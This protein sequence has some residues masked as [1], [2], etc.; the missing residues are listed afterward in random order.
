MVILVV[1]I[2]FF[3][4]IPLLVKLMERNFFV[5]FERLLQP[6]LHER[7]FDKRRGRGISH[8]PNYFLK[9]ENSPKSKESIH[10]CVSRAKK[11]TILVFG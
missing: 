9:S 11:F 2:A 5:L 4:K 1:F 8:P 10:F 3:N 7:P 6:P